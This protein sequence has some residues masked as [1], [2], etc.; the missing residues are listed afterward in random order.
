[1]NITDILTYNFFFGVPPVATNI[2]LPFTI[3]FSLL[4]ILAIVTK[5]IKGE[6]G[7][8]AERFYWPTLIAGIIGL[9]GLFARYESL[10]WLS[11]RILIVIAFA[12]F[13]VSLVVDGI[14]VIRH[15]P[16]TKRAKSDQERYER[17]LPKK[18]KSS[19]IKVKS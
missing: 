9:I 2:Y 19:N 5:L 17:Y 14:W 4:I 16:K 13:F 3:V 12:I 18:A 11:A 10:P 1:M 6:A 7:K 8:L 15:I